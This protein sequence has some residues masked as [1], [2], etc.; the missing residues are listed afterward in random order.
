M[1]VDVSVKETEI[2]VRG[3]RR[4]STFLDL[5]TGKS[6]PQFELPSFVSFSGRLGIWPCR[7]SFCLSRLENWF[8]LLK[9]LA[10]FCLFL[11]ILFIHL[12]QR[13]TD[14]ENMSRGIGRG[15]GRSSLSTEQRALCRARSQY[16]GIMTWAK[17][18]SS[19]IWATQV[20]CQF[21]L[22]QLLI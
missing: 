4:K 21:L 15:R 13:D 3:K 5:V 12:I 8:D 22:Y 9:L 16:P 20:P 7:M 19:T 10:I 2:K 1:L 6:D 17:G 18:R 11:K 14:R